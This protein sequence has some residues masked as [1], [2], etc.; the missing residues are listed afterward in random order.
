VTTALEMAWAT[1]HYIVFYRFAIGFAFFF[2]VLLQFFF[3]AERWLL[4][5]R[6]RS[7]SVLILAAAGLGLTTSSGR[8]GIESNF[9]RLVAEGAS[10]TALVAYLISSHGL[11]VYYLLMLG[12]LLGKDVL[13]SHVLGAIAVFI[14]A[15]LSLRFVF[16]KTCKPNQ[17]QGAVDFARLTSPSHQL[18]RITGTELWAAGPRFLYGLLLGGLIAAWGLS[19]WHVVPATLW[20]SGIT[21][22]SINAVLGLGV[23]FLTWMSPVA[24]LFVGTYVW[25]VGIAHAGLVSFF[26]G[27][28]VSWPRVRLYQR[29]LGQRQGTVF[30]LVLVLAVV[31]AG[32]LV[33]LSFH[34]TPLSINYKLIAEQMLM[35]VDEQDR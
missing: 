23:S 11:T 27:S 18:A 30:A 5:I 8:Q 31:V 24:N 12:P 25:K 9:Q 3:P 4:S 35:N 34:L 13:L 2:S 22:Q 6:G 1:L 10:L 32:L 15:S 20:E 19:P 26:F 28:L 16:G 17:P 21:T 33:A 29:V 7:G 14:V